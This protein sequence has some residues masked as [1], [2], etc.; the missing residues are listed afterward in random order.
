[1][2][3][4]VAGLVRSGLVATRQDPVDRRVIRI[5]ATAKGRSLL[6]A[7]RGRRVKRLAKDLEQLGDGAF[8][9]LAEAMPTIERLSR[10]SDA[11]PVRKGH[12]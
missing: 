11:P 9:A 3:R 6:Q 1:M 7:G 12:E 5:R 4:L 2:S 10:P 8:R